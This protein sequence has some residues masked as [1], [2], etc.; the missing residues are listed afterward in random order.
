MMTK[1]HKLLSKSK[2]AKTSKKSKK[3]KSEKEYTI[4]EVS[5]HNKLNDAWLII[6]NK[7]YN[8]TKWIPNHPGGNIILNGIGK[9]ATGLFNSVG[10]SNNAK[11][12]LKSMYIGVV[13][14]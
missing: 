9:D 4:K 1:N 14:K 2:K 12:I 6:N 10:H 7:V 5:K 8:V 11:K 3:N 13:K